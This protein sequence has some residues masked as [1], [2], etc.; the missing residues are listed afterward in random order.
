MNKGMEVSTFLA[1]IKRR[2]EA[3]VDYLAT[4][5][6]MFMGDGQM[7]FRKLGQKRF[8][9][10]ELAHQQLATYLGIPMSYY[11]KMQ[12][13]K[14]A[15]LD[16]S[17]NRWIEKS[18]EKRF[19][20]TLDGKIRAFLSDK[21]KPY[22]NAEALLLQR[23]YVKSANI[24]DNR[25][26]LQMVNK[27]FEGEVAKGDVVQGGVVI[28]NSEV[29]LGRFKIEKMLYRLVCLNGAIMGQVIGKT[30]VGRK[31]NGEDGIVYKEDTMLAD[32][33]AFNLQVRDILEDALGEGSFMKMLENAQTASTI[34]IPAAS[35]EPVLQEVTKRYSFGEEGGKK[36]LASLIESRDFSKWGLAN[37]I[38]RQ[39]HDTEDYDRS[40]DYQR[41]GGEIISMPTNEWVGMVGR[42]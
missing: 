14:P 39:A 41:I 27:R 13:Q 37:A 18:D 11:R 26:Y 24:S 31:M 34:E 7:I 22:D 10:S 29:G 15:L 36:M 4:S 1:E 16:Y 21:F 30:H 20:R 23:L 32:V 2:E 12:T 3:K 19:V 8:D 5:S 33:Q 35:V 42:S 9:V 40:V 38:T 28:S 6:T 25:L 17:V